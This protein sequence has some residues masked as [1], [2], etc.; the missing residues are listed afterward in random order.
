MIIP[1]G[2]VQFL[3]AVAEFAAVEEPFGRVFFLVLLVDIYGQD[4]GACGYDRWLVVQEPGV[5][6]LELTDLVSHILDGL[7]RVIVEDSQVPLHG[8]HRPGKVKVKA[9][10]D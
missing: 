6:Q 7:V 8:L 2:Q 10:L 5:V 4:H 1:D 9:H 3:E